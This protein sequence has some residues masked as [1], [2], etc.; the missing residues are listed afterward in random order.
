MDLCGRLLQGA[1]QRRN[2]GLI[3][4]GES[5]RSPLGS[6]GLQRSLSRAAGRIALLSLGERRACG[7]DLAV[8]RGD[9]RT[10][11]LEGEHVEGAN[12]R[13]DAYDGQR[14]AITR[15]NVHQEAPPVVVVTGDA[16]GAAAG[17]VPVGVVEPA[18]VVDALVD[19]AAKVSEIWNDTR[20]GQ[21]SAWPDEAAGASDEGLLSEEVASTTSLTPCTLCSCTIVWATV[22]WDRAQPVSWT[23]GGNGVVGAADAVAPVAEADA[24]VA[25]AVGVVA[26]SVLSA[27][28]AGISPPI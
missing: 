2:V 12:D 9:L 1:Q 20:N 19:G 28:S 10:L 25:V 5:H 27:A 13:K 26:W 11:G 4:H 18:A 8:E 22:D 7:G 6:V 14:D 15:A 21:P 24:G 3:W 16:V 23:L 17:V